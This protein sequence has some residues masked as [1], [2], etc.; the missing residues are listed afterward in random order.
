LDREKGV[1]AKSCR[2]RDGGT[3]EEGSKI[4]D[5][6]DGSDSWSTK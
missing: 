3:G 6:Q 5:E 4:E 1:G 2:D